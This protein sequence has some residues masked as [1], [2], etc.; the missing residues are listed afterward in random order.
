MRKKY[1]RTLI[2]ITCLLFSMFGFITPIIGDPL[3]TSRT[4]TLDADF[5]DGV[6]VGVEH[7]T[8]HDQLQLSEEYV[9]L[10]FIWVPNN[11]GT[12]SKINTETGKEIGRYWVSPDPTHIY[13]PGISGSPSRTT[14]DLQGNC[15]VGCRDA[16]TVVKIGLYEAG[17]YIDRNND[18]IIQTSRDLNDDGVITGGE[19][20]PWGQDECVLFEVVLY[21]HPMVTKGPYAPGTFPGPY[22]T[23]HWRTSP[24]G[25]AIDSENNLWAGTC[26]TNYQSTMNCVYHYID[27]VT[28]E[29]LNE[30][31]IIGHY[32]YGAVIDENG[33]LWSA[34][35]PTAAGTP[36]LLRFNPEN[37]AYTKLFNNKMTYGMGL[38]HIGNLFFSGWTQ[39]NLNK[40]D[41]NSNSLIWTVT[42]SS[43][44][45]QTRGVTCTSDNDVWVASTYWSTVSRYNNNG[46]LIA[47]IPVGPNPSGVSV[48]ASG[49]VWVCSMADDTIHRINPLT[50]T[51]DKVV[52]ISGSGGH[53]SY[54]DMTG[55]MARTI[56]TKIG[57]WTVNFDSEESDTP[58]GTISWNSLEPDE[59][60]I[61]IKVR[62][63]ND[64]TTW[65]SWEEAFNGNALSS[66][67][68]GQ[69]L[70][71]EVTFQTDED[72]ISPIL[73]DLTVEVGN[74]PPVAEVGGPYIGYE[75]SE[76]IFD[77]SE[78]FDPDGTIVLYEW[79]FN[80]DG[81]YEESSISPIIGYTWND[82]Y[83]GVV[84]L[85]VTDDQGEISTDTADVIVNNVAPIVTIDTIE[86]MQKFDLEESTFIIRDFVKFTGIAY[87][88]GCDDL[89]FNW[90]WGDGTD[91][92]V[93]TYNNDGL[94]YPVEIEETV[95][96][97]YNEPGVYT[98]TLTVED[99]DG[100]I[101]TDD[102]EIKI[103]GPQDLKKA[104]LFELESVKTDSRCIDFKIYLAIKL[105]EKSLNEKFWNDA[106]HLES[107][108]GIMV[109]IYEQLAAASLKKDLDLS[110]FETLILKLIKADELL[111]EIA[112]E[113]AEA[114][115]V[116]EPI[117]QKIVDFYLAR[118][119]D[120][121]I[122]ATESIE[123][124]LYIS[125]IVHY[126]LAWT[127]SQ[128]A[129]SW[130][131]RECKCTN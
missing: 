32:A 71:I 110:Q 27:G 56:T 92:T 108:C 20:L 12:V 86:Q 16:G 14:V 18:G 128:F 7:D 54:S 95:D 111:A 90:D 114:T 118:V 15:W 73:Y 4:Y 116:K 64:E 44:L 45:Y 123:S 93:T 29:I 84:N 91:P 50:N 40:V 69:Y 62:S 49:K 127:Y 83:T 102:A 76:I 113:D 81:I 9:T 63:S 121:M 77:A 33:I 1:F 57:T 107:K 48:D 126:K 88:P 51:V 112:L 67:P 8:I 124:G 30:V 34:N 94:T 60:S 37:F 65:S 82:D 117:F 101:G 105:I 17:Q 79:D 41:V 103:W 25:L 129:I 122:K 31:E 5:D 21:E 66:T 19:L 23:S 104:V 78:S 98:I 59:T 10:P 99:D 131:N 38:D 55:L 13:Y 3:V 109:F 80:E 52:H 11:E 89:I 120:Q 75:G 61:V 47:T 39:Y 6:L 106:T 125:A 35:R 58:W 72:E 130:A 53:Y 2:L 43:R 96:H 36:H 74:L 28:G 70:Q 97:I 42:D 24:R 119:N 115:P 22:D 100:G 87:D 46:G 68:N 85:R 26:P